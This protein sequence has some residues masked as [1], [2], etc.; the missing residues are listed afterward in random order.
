M[1]LVNVTIDGRADFGVVTAGG[2]ADGDAMSGS[3][4]D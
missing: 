3:C 4:F 1:K 2:P